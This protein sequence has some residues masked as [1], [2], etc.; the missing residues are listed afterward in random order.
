MSY[1][2]LRNLCEMCRIAGFPRPISI[3]SFREPNFPLVAELLE[4]IVLRYEPNALMSTKCSTE[5][6]RVIFIKSAVLLLIQ[7]ARIKLNPKKLYMADGHAVQELVQ[8]LKILSLADRGS[9]SDAHAVTI[10]VIRT[11][12]AT[13]LQ[14]VRQCAS[15]AA[16][17]PQTGSTLS[18]LLEKELHY[19]ADRS[20]ALSRALPP[21]EAE[22]ALRN[23]TTALSTLATQTEDKL[24]NVTSDEKALDEKIERKRREY[25]QMQKRLAK[26]QSFRPQYMDEYE[27]YET[28]LKQL[29]DIYVLKFRNLSYLQLQMV[30]M[31]RADRQRQAET[32]TNMRQVVEKM[33]TDNANQAPPIDVSELDDEPEAMRP[34]GG[35]R[36]IY[37]NMMGVGFSDEEEDSDDDVDVSEGDE[38]IDHGRAMKDRIP[39][40]GRSRKPVQHLELEDVE[41]EMAPREG[42]SGDDF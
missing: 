42:D 12:L 5:Q 27:K 18:S 38:E 21:S 16:Q 26:L 4:W 30:E 7:N 14:E 23:A 24:N 11:K 19:R 6:E 3:D 10:P 33:R 34:T 36:R 17:L 22:K 8:P 29:Y 2:E 25:E 15:L 32:E 20:R 31:E 1:R 37:G 13:K 28:K 9:T 41:D 39:A 40:A 35:A